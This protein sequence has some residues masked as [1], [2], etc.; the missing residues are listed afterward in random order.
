MGDKTRETYFLFHL[1]VFDRPLI[2]SFDSRSDWRTFDKRTI[3]LKSRYSSVA[4]MGLTGC[5]LRAGFV[6]TQRHDEETC[7][8]DSQ[9]LG[10]TIYLARQAV[11]E[12]SIY[13]S[14]YLT[15]VGIPF[16]YLGN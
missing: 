11:Y 14:T 10:V 7:H 12:L 5:G 13:L 9:G 15:W 2:L 4:L 8:L 16:I 3:V 6:H 1:V